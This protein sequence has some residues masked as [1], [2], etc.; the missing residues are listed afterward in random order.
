[1]SVS[2]AAS[3][4]FEPA[5]CLVLLLAACSGGGSSGG[6]GIPSLDWGSFRRDGRNS[7]LASG[8]IDDNDGEPSLVAGDLGGVTLSTPAIDSSGNV[9]VG[10]GDGLL[11]L[12]RAGDTRWRF[13]RCDL[14]DGTVDVGPVHSSPTVTPDGAIVIGSDDAAGFG[15]YVFGLQDEGEEITCLWKFRPTGAGADFRVRSSALTVVDVVDLSLIWVFVG[16]SDGRFQALNG[17]DGSPQWVFPPGEPTLGDV[18]STA[19]LSSAGVLYLT[20]PNGLLYALDS[21]GRQLW[22]FSI[23]GSQTAAGGLIPSPSVSD[24][25]YAIGADATVVAVNPDGSLKWRFQADAAILGS[26]GFAAQ[27]IDDG[28]ETVFETVVYVVDER[29]T[30]YGIRESNGQLAVFNRCSGS[31]ENLTCTP[32]S[33]DPDEGTC[34]EEDRLCSV[35]KDSCMPDSCLPDNGTCVGRQAKVA[36]F[37]GGP[38]AVRTSP[39][40]SSDMFAVVGSDD[41]RVCA[42]QLDGTIPQTDE[43]DTP[44]A[45]GCIS[46]PDSQETVSSPVIDREGT[47]YVTTDNGLY[48]IK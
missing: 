10:T 40:I 45:N 35:S 8:R 3:M 48:S 39:A 21:S 1:M 18:T 46:I 14:P 31:E 7:G 4:R 34:G 16:L 24:T 29:G 38:L 15:G 5:I 42:R 9:Y 41:G 20:A 30:L 12:D 28:S 43:T 32:D 23:G 17:D 25:V 44:W 27:S 22:Q 6:S 47:I 36:V 13:T 11:S 26:P 2:S 33:C 19:V 37:S